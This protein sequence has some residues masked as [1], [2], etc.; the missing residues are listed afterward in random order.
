MAQHFE[1]GVY[2]F[3]CTNLIPGSPGCSAPSSCLGAKWCLSKDKDALCCQASGAWAN[4][5]QQGLLDQEY[6]ETQGSKYTRVRSLG[7]DKAME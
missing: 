1:K 4:S 7:G 2:V 6:V 3:L 5:F